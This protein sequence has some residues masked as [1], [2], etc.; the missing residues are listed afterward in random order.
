MEALYGDME[1]EG[2]AAVEGANVILQQIETIRSA[3][4]RYVGQE[5][6]VT[7]DLPMDFFTCRDRAGIKRHFD[8][9]HTKRYGYANETEEA[10][11][12][13]LRN[14]VAGRL[15]RPSLEKIPAGEATA[16]PSASHGKRPVYFN[17][18]ERFVET[19]IYERDR[20]LAG[21]RLIGPALVEEY[22]STTVVHPEDTLDVDTFGNLV[23][24]IGRN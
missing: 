7:V 17:E 20:L 18:T 19:L 4:M 8:A 1:R 24:E 12:V 2:I 3:D 10:E 14:A 13:S 21:N 6:A 11:I 16:P 15:S 23:I 9:V 5:H 22:A